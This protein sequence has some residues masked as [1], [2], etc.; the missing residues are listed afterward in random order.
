VAGAR[1]TPVGSQLI[2]VAARS[3]VACASAVA[4]LSHAATSL[5]LVRLLVFLSTHDSSFRRER[6]RLSHLG[7]TRP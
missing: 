3:E 2:Y 4:E 5:G 7:R 6:E 1:R